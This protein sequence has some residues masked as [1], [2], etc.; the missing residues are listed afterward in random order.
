MAAPRAPEGAPAGRSR[1]RRRWG[2]D[3]GARAARRLALAAALWLILPG[4]APA[5]PG[6]AP[7][8]GQ[9]EAPL[10][11]RIRFEGVEQLSEKRLRG[12]MRLRQ[13][14][15]WRPFQRS[16][17]YGTDQLERD[18]ERV[19]S[20]YRGEGFVL[21]RIEGVAVRHLSRELVDL[22]VRV[23]E[24]PR[25][26]LRSVS[27]GDAPPEV[28]AEA[29]GA[30]EARPGQPLREAQLQL[31]ELRLQRLCEE[32][33]YA[34]AE[35]T[36]EQR[37][38]ADSVDVVFWVAAGPR[39]R[40]G[41]ID[42]SGLTRT[43]PRVVRRE[44]RVAPGEIFR[45]SRAAASQERLFEL[46]LFRT[47]RILPVPP[48]SLAPALDRPELTM[49]LRVTLAE[50]PP[51]W[52][53]FGLG[54][55][56]SDQLRLLGEWGY[57]NLMG[58]ARALQV[59]GL[60]AF[61]LTRAA[62]VSRSAPKERLV[63][64]I[65]TEPWV[66]GSLWGQARTYAHFN[67]EATFEE[68]IYGLVL[69]GRRD[70]SR[71]ERLF[72]SIENKWVATTD[73]SAA[74]ADYQ[75][76]FL[77]LALASDRRDFALDPQSGSYAQL[78]GEYAGGFLGGAASFGRIAASGSIYRPLARRL[79]WAARVRG[80]TIHPFGREPVAG[81]TES[82]LLRVPFEERFR[83]GGGTTV[84]GHAEGS[85][86]PYSAGNQVLG[87]LVLLVMNTEVRFPLFWE[88]GGAVFL[89]AGNVWADY[90]DIS[91]SRW[92]NGWKR[93]DYSPLDAVYGMGGGVRLRTPV[94]PVR[95]DYGLKLGRE[96]PGSGRGEWH[97]S[98]GQAF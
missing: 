38:R 98:L 91:W 55:S 77:S 67:R 28:E 46:G 6:A 79:S 59:K 15:W 73:S 71:G 83:A 89:D 27:V 22:E 94:G 56:S 3:R 2:G 97:F 78:R 11:H 9:P 65:Y 16:H 62:G 19:L 80:G 41:Q 31:D 49:D 92:A 52:Y 54:L 33:G 10:V 90:R 30:L 20:L 14:A 72:G 18:L 85:L 36:Q 29:R 8:G 61:A 21:A 86:G 81:P 44:I 34:L 32:E 51:G 7:G 70:L 50:K 25:A 75:T 35:V 60:V 57:R 69:G 82:D 64:V 45:R 24:G 23:R 76:R 40:V 48:D 88:F 37:F 4:G 95:L 43:R 17:F 63:E 26:Y 87:G 47:V 84:R 58:R 53:G 68:Q 42:I 66:L 1:R 5:P 96:R 74:Q 93:A 12:T 13:K 39:V